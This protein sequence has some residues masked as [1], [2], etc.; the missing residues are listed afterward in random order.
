MKFFTRFL[1]QDKKGNFIDILTLLQTQKLSIKKHAIEHAIDLIARTISKCEIEC[2]K[3]NS[4]L[5]KLER[6]KNSDTYYRLNIKSNDN[7]IA[8]TFI[9]NV[10]SKLLKDEEVLIIEIGHK[11]YLASDFDYD[12]KILKEKTFKNIKL[13]DNKGNILSLEK[14]FKSS[15]CIYLSLG[16]SEIKECLD[17]Y[18]KELGKLISIQNKKYIMSNINKW[19]LNV[20]GT[21][22]KMLDPK[23]GE[24][25]DYKDYKE[26]LT[27]GLMDEEDAIIM[28][29]Q[30]FDLQKLSSTEEKYNSEDLLRLQDKWEK[31]VAMAFNIPLDVYYGSK[32]DKSTG[33]NDFITFAI[34][35]VTSILEDGFNGSLIKKRNFLNGDMIK[36]NK[37][38]I[39]HFDIFDC[40][41]SIDK[42]TSSGFSHDENRYFLGIPETGEKWAQEHHITKNYANVSDSDGGD[43]MT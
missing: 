33:T 4:E 24:P 30:D 34:T 13:Q 31:E 40:A 42:L 35:P 38:N 14:E 43:S 1:H 22:P 36:I 23:T 10:V 2:Y 16:I 7:E 19:K 5:K 26:K 6:I 27:D 37:L 18:Y 17:D 41:N 3:Y 9:Y 20:P 15:K 39:K 11:L 8:T 21:Q 28:L 32:T 29:S 25:I 12:E